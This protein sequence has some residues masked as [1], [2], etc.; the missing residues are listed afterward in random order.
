[1]GATRLVIP[2]SVADRLGATKSGQV[3]VRYADGRVA[4]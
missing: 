1:M 3:G 2:E 4:T